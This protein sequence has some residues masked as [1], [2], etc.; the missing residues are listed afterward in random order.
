MP[1]SGVKFASTC[2]AG[3]ETGFIFTNPNNFLADD[4]SWATRGV[5]LGLNGFT[6]F[7]SVRL[8]IGGS[9]VGSDYA[10]GSLTTTDA[11]AT[12]GGIS[13]KWGLTPT[14]A[15]INA[16]DFGVFV[17]MRAVNSGALT[18]SLQLTNFSMG[19]TAGATIDG[20]NVEVKG[21]YISSRGS[22]T[23]YMNCARITVYYT[24]SAGGAA[25]NVIIWS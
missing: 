6:I 11:Y 13:D 17:S 9:V 25:G 24:E 22:V 20:I 18:E 2:T 4:S 5:D 15:Q 19:V 7:N 3:A 16:S 8:I 1:N 21:K 10:T 12:F 23:I 14:A